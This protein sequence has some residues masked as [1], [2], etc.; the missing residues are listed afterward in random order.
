MTFYEKKKKKKKQRKQRNPPR[1]TSQ[2]A[3]EHFH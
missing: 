3:R 2:N 1:G